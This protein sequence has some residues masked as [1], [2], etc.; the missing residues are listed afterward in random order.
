MLAVLAVLMA[1]LAPPISHALVSWRGSAAAYLG[2]I[3][4]GQGS[5]RATGDSSRDAGGHGDRSVPF[6]HCPFCLAH[7]GSF[8]LPPSSSVAIPTVEGDHFV[9]PLFFRSPRPLFTWAAAQPRA[10]PLAA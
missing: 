6:E 9:P 8:G 1:A 7:A 5:P 2:E 10:P 4:T 3:C